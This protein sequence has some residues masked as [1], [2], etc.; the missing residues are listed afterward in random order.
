MKC[1][2]V[3]LE[4]ILVYHTNYSI[5]AKATAAFG[6][7]EGFSDG[8]F[9]SPFFFSWPSIFRRHAKCGEPDNDADDERLPQP[10]SHQQ[11]FSHPSG[12][13]G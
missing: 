2:Q 13:G 12:L 11:W 1:I 10:H 4:N 8:S 5:E 3:T 6:S 7:R 9:F